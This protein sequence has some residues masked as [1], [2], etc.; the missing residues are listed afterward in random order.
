M[1]AST[2]GLENNVMGAVVGSGEH[3]MVYIYFPSVKRAMGYLKEEKVNRS[4]RDIYLFANALARIIAHEVLHVCFPGLPHT[5]QGL[6]A[7]R[8]NSKNLEYQ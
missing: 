7:R 8:W 2:W 3:R 6:M 5:H 1:D 4:P